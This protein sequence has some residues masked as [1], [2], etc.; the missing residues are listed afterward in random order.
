MS[1]TRALYARIKSLSNDGNA[2]IPNPRGQAEPIANMQRLTR[3]DERD[4]EARDVIASMRSAF[5][6]VPYGEIERQ[7]EGTINGTRE[8]DRLA[9]ERVAKT[10]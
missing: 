8:E 6:V 5:A 4:L 9:R 7:T 3:L 2:V 1:R 10:A